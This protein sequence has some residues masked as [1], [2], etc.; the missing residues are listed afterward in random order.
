MPIGVLAKTAR[1]APRSERGAVIDDAHQVVERA[2]TI[3]RERM[4]VAADGTRVP[5]DVETI[6]VHGDTRGAAELAS[7]I[8]KALIDVGVQV[9]AP[10]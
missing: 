1:W 4:V 2:V 8:R 5:L 3:A 9:G 6:C 7:R 10:I